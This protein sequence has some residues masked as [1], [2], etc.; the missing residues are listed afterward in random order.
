MNRRALQ[1]GDSAEAVESLRMSLERTGGREIRDVRVRQRDVRAPGLQSHYVVDRSR[2]LAMIDIDVTS[3]RR[4]E[5]LPERIEAA[6]R[7]A[8]H[9][10]DHGFRLRDV[11]DPGRT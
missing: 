10:P 2:T 6:A 9:Q 1:D 5:R 11:V 4:R 8:C 3:I 7:R